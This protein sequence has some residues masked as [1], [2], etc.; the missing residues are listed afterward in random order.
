[1]ENRVEK[2]SSKGTSEEY[3]NVREEI[4]ILLLLLLLELGYHCFSPIASDRCIT[5]CGYHGR[6][7]SMKRV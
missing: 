7:L 6:F 5:L 1:M 4:I 2:P 3:E